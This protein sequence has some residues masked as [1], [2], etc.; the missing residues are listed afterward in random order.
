MTLGARITGMLVAVMAVGAAVAAG[1]WSSAGGAGIIPPD[2]PPANIAP[3]STD[4]L[5]SI[6]SAR[7]VEGVVPMDVDET[8]LAALPVSEQLFI[9]VN[10]ER[11]DRGL[12]PF[13]YLTNQLDASAQQGA[14]GDQDPAI[15]TVLTGGGTVTSGAAVWAGGLPSALEADYYWMYDDGWGGLASLTMNAD[16]SLATMAQ[17]WGHRDDILHHFDN[18]GAAPPTLS[19]GAGYSPTGAYGSSIAAEMVSSCGPPPPDVVMTWGQV[20]SH[21]L[22]APVVPSTRT[23]AMAALADGAGYWEAEANGTV[24]AFGSAQNYG[25]MAGTDLNSPIVGMAA[26]PNGLGYWLVA[27]DG[28]IFSFGNAVF[29]GS[30]GSLPLKAPIVGLAATPDGRGYWLVASDGGIF[31]FGDATYHGS[32]GGQPLNR[33]VI[34]MAT[35]AATGGYWLV[36]SDGGVFS[37]DARFWGSTGGIHLDQPI[38][39]VAALG[40]GQ[41]YRFEAADGGV[42]CF[43]RAIYDGSMG[44]QPLSAPVVAMAPDQATGGY[45][46]AAADGGIFSFGG[47]PYLGRI[48]SS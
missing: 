35:D 45:W 40:N 48:A 44:G 7:A 26:T 23:V 25:S 6:D 4:Y 2:N 39:G 18:C 27:A 32:M 11:I 47:A 37:F 16:C 41:G 34:G 24:A 19:M 3:S 13:T 28:G 30:A 8:S 15:P 46:L 21:A 12:L 31:S 1:N 29:Y 22:S 33:P 10:L 36:A 43:G 42:F 5:A 17:C 20:G 14:D 9:L 38:V